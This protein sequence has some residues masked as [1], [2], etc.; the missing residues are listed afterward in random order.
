MYGKV[1]S[2]S[3]CSVESYML[4]YPILACQCFNLLLVNYL[5]LIS[6]PPFN[7]KKLPTP[8]HSFFHSFTILFVKDLKLDFSPS[9]P[10]PTKK[11]FLCP[12]RNIKN[13]PILCACDPNGW[14]NWSKSTRVKLA[15]GGQP[16]SS[17]NYKNS[18]FCF[19]D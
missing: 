15:A 17:I 16:P 11:S 12:C 13:L 5:K 3:G 19:H 4:Y 6:S 18:G 14:K 2:P 9:S 8:L 10:S 1:I 7:E